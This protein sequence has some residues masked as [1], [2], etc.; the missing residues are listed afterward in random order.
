MQP[1]VHCPWPEIIGESIGLMGNTARKRPNPT[2]QTRA[3][4]TY[5]T[6]SLH[7][8]AVGGVQIPNGGSTFIGN[9]SADTSS[10]AT[11][12][13]RPHVAR[14][15]KQRESADRQ[16]KNK[17]PRWFCQ[18]LGS[19]LTTGEMLPPMTSQTKEISLKTLMIHLRWGDLW[20]RSNFGTYK[21]DFD[22]NDVTLPMA[23]TCG[24]QKGSRREIRQQSE[25]NSFQKKKLKTTKNGTEHINKKLCWPWVCNSTST[26]LSKELVPQTHCQLNKVFQTWF[27]N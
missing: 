5:R 21:G 22:A 19:I 25:A 6:P 17:P 16:R 18:L 10:Y 27:A 7:W 9:W 4:I 13:R 20:N 1:I 14:W 26:S 8:S 15:P 23:K 24:L 3:H 11:P 12:W 2:K